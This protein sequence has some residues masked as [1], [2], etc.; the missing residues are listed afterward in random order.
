MDLY[1]S[2]SFKQLRVS[3][4]AHPSHLCHILIGTNCWW[5]VWTVHTVSLRKPRMP[6]P[7][8]SPSPPQ[9]P[10]FTCHALIT[11]L[12]PPYSPLHSSSPLIFHLVTSTFRSPLHSDRWTAASHP[13]QPSGS[14]GW[15]RQNASHPRAPGL[16]TL[17]VRL[18]R[19]YD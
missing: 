12:I 19:R 6:V 3:L 1:F 4:N 17:V 15:P 9:V 11:L 10:H 14:R 18:G 7:Q 8:Q 13:W 5:K 16:L 2:Q